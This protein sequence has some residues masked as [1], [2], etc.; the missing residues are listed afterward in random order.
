MRRAAH[1]AYDVIRLAKCPVLTFC[2]LGE[3]QLAGSRCKTWPHV[4]PAFRLNNA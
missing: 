4:E 1:I 2:P 3:K